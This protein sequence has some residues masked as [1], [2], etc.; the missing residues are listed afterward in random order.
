VPT[1]MP[2]PIAIVVAMPLEV[3]PLVRSLPKRDVEGMAL[4]QLPGAVVVVGGIGERSARKASE[5]AVTY[6]RP[7]FLV[8]A[9][10]AGGVSPKLKVGDV[11]RAK[12]VVEISSGTRYPTSGGDWVLVTGATVSGPEAKQQLFER[13]GAD[14]VDM[15]AAAV[16]QVAQEHGLKL[17][18]IKSVSD[19]AQFLLPPLGRFVEDD[20]KFAMRRFLAYVAVRPKWW[21][22]VTRLGRNSRRASK[23]LAMA[24]NHLIG[25]HAQASQ[26]RASLG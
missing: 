23:S 13:Y 6:A 1:D 21:R 3:A 11:G 22:S 18:I 5:M 17:I 19:V 24:L 2:K 14:V 10:L 20:G 4:F 12:E 15:E 7:E 16:A 25:E 9:G 26:E 8:N